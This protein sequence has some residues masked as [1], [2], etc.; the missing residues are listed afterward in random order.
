MTVFFLPKKFRPEDLPSVA[1][2]LA[3]LQSVFMK[4]FPGCFGGESAKALAAAGVVES[5][6]YLMDGDFAVSDILSAAR[7]S[8]VHRGE[9]EKIAT[10]T[11]TLAGFWLD[12][13]INPGKVRDAV[14]VALT[15]IRNGENPR[16]LLA[17]AAL[18]FMTRPDMTPYRLEIGLAE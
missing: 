16:R 3:W 14:S 18:G 6:A 4:D 17:N 12:G 8:A 11:K 15:G 5:L 2:E 10:F 9:I 7:A 13:E 1:G